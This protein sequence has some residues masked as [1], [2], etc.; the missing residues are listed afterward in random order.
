MTLHIRDRPGWGARPPSRTP[1]PA[2]PSKIRAVSHHFI[3][4]RPSDTATNGQFARGV[5]RWHMDTMGWSDVAY[6]FAVCRDGEVMSMRG[7]WA[8]NFAEGGSTRTELPRLRGG[9]A[10]LRAT[11]GRDH[12]RS[13]NPHCVSVVWQSGRTVGPSGSYD[14]GADERPPAAQIAA[15]RAL[16]DHIDSQIPHQL[17]VDVHGGHRTKTC[18]GGWIS[19]LA[20]TGE[21]G[22]TAPGTRFARPGELTRIQAALAAEHAA[23]HAPLPAAETDRA[24]KPWH[25][26]LDA[27][28]EA[29][30]TDGTNPDE[31]CKRRH[32]AIMAY[33]AVRLARRKDSD[34]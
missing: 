2:D 34:V 1:K 18:P 31:P 4:P 21:L 20:E 27:A 16:H 5:Q 15:A 13:W 29:G 3:G 25:W 19:W 23:E 33:R 30:I 26:E 17:L 22:P 12:A 11:Y 8:T 32:A 9:G 28:I 24:P 10:H 6:G 7:V 14:D